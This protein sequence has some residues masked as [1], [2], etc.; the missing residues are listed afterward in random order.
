MIKRV[1]F[2]HPR[3]WS[4][5]ARIT[6]LV[7]TTAALLAVFAISAALL[8]TANL[9]QLDVVLNKTGVLRL[10]G[11][12][13]GASLVDQETG[14]RGYVLSGDAADLG[15]YRS[16][17][18]AE[19]RLYET[20]IPLLA[21]E[22]AIR[23]QLERA[24][25]AATT[26]RTT[27][28]EPAV[29][30]TRDQG[31]AAGQQ[32]LNQVGGRE[33]FDQARAQLAT[34]QQEIVTLRNAAVANVQSGSEN[35][36]V[37]LIAAGLVV[38]VMG[39]ILV[40]L[41]NRMV[42]RPVTHLAE[43]VRHVASGAYDTEI[44]ATGSPELERLGRDVDGMRRQIASDLSE[45]R[46]ARQAVELINQ[47]L[48]QQ[49]SEL[50]RSNRDLEQFAYVASHDLQ[51]PLRKVASF[52]QLLQRRYAGQLD[53]RADQYILFAVDGAQRMQR[54]IN[55]LLAFSRIG[56]NT[57]GFQPVS[58][59]A[60][61]RA[62]FEQLNVEEKYGADA[63]TWSELPTVAGEEALLETLLANLV[64]NSLK[65]RRTDVPAR[66]EVS[67]VRE[68]DAWDITVS[69]NGIGIEAE[70]AEKIFIIF[71]RLHAKDA[72]PGTG[73]G[74]AIAKKIV[75]YHDGRIWVDSSR[76]DGAAITFSLPIS[77][78]AGAAIQPA[79]PTQHKELT[80]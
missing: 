50:T 64:G 61:M 54:L 67:A 68:D 34:L 27:V 22:P 24:R 63:V 16:G 78:D 36:V 74:L 38:L 37:L 6:A 23:A 31:P 49:A 76:T 41:I 80:A 35:L 56:R 42:S 32:L 58:L 46:E 33:R 7:T 55:D 13:L 57:S 73:M 18:E 59:D 47:Q 12:Q 10:S 17:R 44:V 21:D 48:Q 28:A 26:W 1:Q 65:F 62:V 70:F 45:V 11:E 69:D 75:E 43:Q 30:A 71:Q 51:E 53:E 79:V 9:D 40:V 20:M 72:Y 8:A 29:T 19:E 4:L 60:V 25:A 77:E 14:V 5:R 15:P 52:C 39:T 3:T 2:T 66:I